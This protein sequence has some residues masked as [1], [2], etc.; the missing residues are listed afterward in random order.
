VNL[1]CRKIEEN[2]LKP[3]MARIKIDEEVCDTF[4]TSGTAFASGAATYDEHQMELAVEEMFYCISEGH[5]NVQGTSKRRVK[6][7]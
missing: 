7:T 4:L 6:I 5:A 2:I 1:L 3:M